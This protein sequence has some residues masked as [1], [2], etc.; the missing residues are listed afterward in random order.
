[1]D[2]IISLENVS[3]IYRTRRGDVRALDGV[4]LQVNEGEFII[5][6]GH[7]GSGKTT[8]L[9]NIGGML[10]PT[11]GRVIVDGNDVMAVYD[12]AAEAVKRARKGQGPTL[13]ECKTYRQRGHTE[14]DPGTA[15][16]SKKEVE[17]WKQKDPIPRFEHKLIELKALTPKKMDDIKRSIAR[18]IDEGVRFAE[19]SPYPDPSEITTD[20]YTT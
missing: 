15:Y 3:K 14:G 16:R 17:E 10:R 9:L 11:T 19:E 12:A 5:V 18:E 4:S 13:V 2:T 20:V 8:L 6:R 1:M 7:S